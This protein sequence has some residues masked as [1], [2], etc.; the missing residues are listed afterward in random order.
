M[1]RWGIAGASGGISD[2]FAEA[3]ALVDASE[4]VAVASRDQSTAARF[5]SRHGIEHLDTYESLAEREDVDAIYVATP[6]ALHHYAALY[7]KAGKHVLCEKPLATALWQTEALVG[8]AQQR[9]VFLMEAMWCRFL[10][11]YQRLRQLLLDG[12]VGE[13]VQVDAYFGIKQPNRARPE[14]NAAMG[15]GALLTGGCYPVSFAHMI[16]G[17]PADVRAFGHVGESGVDETFTAGL[18]Y[19]SGAVASVRSAITADVGN[20]ARI[21]GT[22]GT[23][24]LSSLTNP[25]TID[26]DPEHVDCPITR[27]RLAY[28][29]EHVEQCLRDGLTESPVMPLAE[30]CAVARTIDQ[31]RA[32]L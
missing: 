5:A 26:G 31:I 24:T 13:V 12:V 19:E 3:A 21:C 17:E 27:P 1:T 25:T 20:A 15:G 10:P 9:G 23:L 22:E 14:F 4:I 6:P 16:L 28:Q 32:Q 30:S 18:L 11:A 7:L 8:A 29:L 2:L